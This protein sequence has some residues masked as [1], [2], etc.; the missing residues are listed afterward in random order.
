MSRSRGARRRTPEPHPGKTSLHTESD[1]SKAYTAGK[2]IR[3]TNRINGPV[4]PVDTYPQHQLPPDSVL[5][6]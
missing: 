3:Y 2:T 5:R 1:S 4:A 6:P